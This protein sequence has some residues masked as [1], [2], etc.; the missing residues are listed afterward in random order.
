MGS[1]YSFDSFPLRLIPPPTLSSPPENPPHRPGGETIRPVGRGCAAWYMNVYKYEYEWE[2][3]HL[4][5][6]SWT[7][8]MGQYIYMGGGGGAGALLIVWLLDWLIVCI[9][10]YR[11]HIHWEKRGDG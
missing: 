6:A 8:K 7:K 1:R 2:F 4:Y 9:M 11:Y 5:S 3:I 10:G